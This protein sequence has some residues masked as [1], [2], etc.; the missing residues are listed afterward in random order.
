MLRVVLLAE[1]IW[2]H[3]EKTCPCGEVVKTLSTSD[4]AGAAGSNLSGCEIF[5]VS[6]R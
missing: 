5:S 6:K 3:A 2:P 4:Y 1:E